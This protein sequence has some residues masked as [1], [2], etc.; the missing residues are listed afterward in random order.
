M[1]ITTM[2][3]TRREQPIR[4]GI[5]YSANG[6]GNSLGGILGYGIGSIN[7]GLPSWKY[8]FLIIGTLCCAWGIVLFIFL[9]DSPVTAKFLS[10]SEKRMAV[11]RLRENQTGI[12]NK[13]F[14]TYQVMEAFTDYKTLLFFLIAFAANVPSAGIS[15]FGTLIVQG[16]GYSTCILLLPPL[17]VIFNIAN[18]N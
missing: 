15:N 17:Q 10:Q 12:E 8:E 7:S 4:L 1:L 6:I 5:W 11:E 16:F 18:D 3:Y 13:H 14:K 9:P 2:W